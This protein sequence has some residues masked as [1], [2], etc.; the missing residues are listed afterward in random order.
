M[1]IL[2]ANKEASEQFPAFRLP[3]GLRT[4]LSAEEAAG[5]VSR[6]R[7]RKH[8]K[9]NLSSLSGQPMSAAF[10]PAED[11]GESVRA[12]VFFVAAMSAQN[13]REM[14]LT[15]LLGYSSLGLSA[16]C[17]N[18]CPIFFTRWHQPEP[19][20]TRSRRKRYREQ[21]ETI[22]RSCYRILRDMD[23]IARRGRAR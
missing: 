17:G 3:D 19:S 4:L 14:P 8:F 20:W 12:Y 21:T 10:V 1:T 22:S 16:G 7:Q 11:S 2:F 6:V 9:Q 23:N 5:C 18:R 15:S 13:D